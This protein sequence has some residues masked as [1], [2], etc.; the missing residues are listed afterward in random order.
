M[1]CKPIKKK[2]CKECKKEFTPFRPL[3]VACDYWCA[4]AIGRKSAQKKQD[5]KFKIKKASF[6]LND[7]QH[8]KELT[9]K[10]FNKLRKLQEFK[11]FADR[12]LEP[13]C[14]SCGKTKMD[15]CCGHFKTVKAQGILRFDSKNTYLQCNKY[16]NSS[17]SGNI[18]GCNKT[19]GYKVGL[20]ER[21]G[22][23]EARAIRDYCESTTAPYKWTG[24]ELSE[25]R[26]RFNAEIR[27]LERD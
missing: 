8:Q 17:K 5:A 19:R 13:S 1:E 21:F 2:K 27:E 6:Y 12:N 9:Q 22:E 4:L 23:D 3:Q 18:E 24:P 25:M 10:A 7:T 20:V 14:I 16:C 15:W 11:W 26:K